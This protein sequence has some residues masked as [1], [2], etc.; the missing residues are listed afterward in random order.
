MYLIAKQRGGHQAIPI[1]TG[2]KW[3]FHKVFVGHKEVRIV[4]R[5]RGR[6]YLLFH[7]RDLSTKY[8]RLTR[9]H[10]IPLCDEIISATSEQITNQH[11]YIEFEHICKAA[12]CRHHRCWRD[13][14]LI[15][16]ATPELYHGHPIDAKTKQLVS[17]VKVTLDDIVVMDHEPPIDVCEQE[18]LPY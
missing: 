2:D 14:G 17:Y 12:E 7:T 16:P 3:D 5:V 1:K 10:L 8:P 18:E 4:L 15:T 13:L 6:R 9:E 11:Q